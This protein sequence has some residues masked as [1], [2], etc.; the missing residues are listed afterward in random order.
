MRALQLR[1]KVVDSMSYTIEE[2]NYKELGV[3]VQEDA[4]IFTFEGER[5][6]DCSILFYGKNYDITEKVRVPAEYSMGSVRSVQIS[7]IKTAQLKYNYEING[8]V[9]TDPYARRIIGREKWN[10]TARADYDYIVCG[11]CKTECFTGK[12]DRQPEVMRQKMLMY[13]LHVRGFS[14]DAGL[15]GKERGTF[16]A[17]QNKI[18][19]LKSLGVTTLEFMPVYEFEEMVLPQK[20]EMPS[21]LNWESEEGDLILPQ[22][23]QMVEKVNYWGY[24][25]GN[26][27][28][29][30]ASYSSTPDAAIEW[31]A[32]IG[33][34]HANG[35]ECVMEMYFEKRM[36]Q[37]V[38]LD[39]LRYWVREYHVDGFHLLG[40][41]LPVTAIA[42]DLLLSRTKIFY[43][44][45]DAMLWERKKAT[46]H[47]FIYS[48]E[49]LYPVRKMLNHMD[50][51]LT[52]FVC[53]QRKQHEVLGFVNYITNN[54]G[55]TLMD[56]FSY[57][58][59]H[60]ESNGEGNCDGNNW[61][62]SI[63][64]GVEG[65][66]GKHYVGKMRR[67]QLR[68]A[69][70]V[71][72]LAQ[73]VPLLL[74]GDEFGNTQEGNNNAYCQDN[75]L[76][77]VNWK[78]GEKYA[79]LQEFVRKMAAFRLA[80]PVIA[81]DLPMALNDHGRKGF[82]DLSYHGENA[83]ISAF[84]QDKQAVG[85]MYCGAYTLLDDGTEDDFIYIGY[86]FHSSLG[87]LA[88]PRLAGQRQ[89]Y[90]VMDTSFETD[91]FLEQEEK[92]KCQQMVAVKA[93]SVVILIGK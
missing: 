74:A 14:M 9:T 88:L 91:A 20:I 71:L 16:R 67:K 86:N 80:H 17:V 84:P 57:S 26:Y 63:N 60:N 61:N 73:G 56:L 22:Q 81:S 64:C 50:G 49:Y 75:R 5:E 35:M 83:W 36:N 66:T 30:K 69:I 34:L 42:Q 92:L 39:A 24:T 43:T 54:N 23:E 29:V 89:W 27:F 6:D 31:K 44:G 51:N 70:A 76:G 38:I 59:K 65:R 79:W 53:Q 87:N 21:Y 11:G 32:L 4:V 45:F 13:K 33:E 28:A 48:E 40:T 15:H 41:S 62:Y 82:P 12:H 93:Q 2:G 78:R 3:Q 47:L 72:M 90:L 10:D 85:L 25:P 37:N 1:Q 58:E 55:F 77:W 18:P 19:Y 52:E 46:S 7:G 8:K 68:N